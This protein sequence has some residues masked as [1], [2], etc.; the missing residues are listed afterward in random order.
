MSYMD[1]IND[2]DLKYLRKNNIGKHMFAEC[3][4]TDPEYTRSRLF[5]QRLDDLDNMI[6]KEGWWD[7]FTL[8][9]TV[10]D[11]GLYLVRIL[12]YRSDKNG[13]IICEVIPVKIVSFTT[14][15]FFKC[16]ENPLTKVLV[17]NS[18]RFID[19]Y[20]YT[21]RGIEPNF[22]NLVKNVPDLSEINYADIPKNYLN[23]M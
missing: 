5:I 23:F 18:G 14:W 6:K 22:K 15:E 17:M 10:L 3:R 8:A 19:D 12:D 9:N 2:I 7:T 21:Y 13:N 11:N 4:G 16:L 1:Y 20:R